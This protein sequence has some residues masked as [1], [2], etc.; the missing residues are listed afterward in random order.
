[1][2]AHSTS[3]GAYNNLGTIVATD[4]TV[5]LGGESSR[6]AGLGSFSRTGGAG[7]KS[8]ESLN[9][10]PGLVLDSTTGDWVIAGGQIVGGV[11]DTLDGTTF[12]GYWSRH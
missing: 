6:I 3:A 12:S 11:L 10:G 9:N 5:N 4:S 7:C 2:V 1:M 8:P